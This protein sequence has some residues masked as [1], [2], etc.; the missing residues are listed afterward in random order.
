[1]TIPSPYLLYLGNSKDRLY[2]KTASGIA[3]WRPELV[4]GQY[5]ASDQERSLD[6]AELSFDEAV[7]AGA[8]TL[9]LGFANEGGYMPDDVVRDVLS[10]LR[11][12]LHVASGLHQHLRDNAQ[13]NELASELGRSLFDVRIPPDGL[14]VGT[15][16]RR[17]GR[18][19]LA[20]G[21]DCSVGKM[22]TSL[23]IEKELKRRNH[24]ARFRAT[25]QTGIL[26]AGGGVPLDAVPG[27]FLS[28]AI[29][30][31]SPARHDNGWDIIEGQ[32]SLFHPSFAAV[33]LGLL[34]G[35]Q[36]DALVLCHEAGRPHIRH[37]PGYRLPGLRECLDRNLQ[38]ARLTNSEAVAVGISLNTSSLSP[39]E[40]LDARTEAEDL[41]G[42]PCEDPLAT[43]VGRIVD[44]LIEEFA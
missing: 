17:A 28:G 12:G 29:E 24:L 16:A 19:L 38:E 30:Q 13:I 1:M 10:A 21:T 2:L 43:G 14:P 7:E 6:L 40:A 34:H 33:S 18:R 41:L 3:H 23:A 22:Y 8:K 15:G 39:A 5:R 4:L 26:I 37:L 11:A 42:L 27:D 20:V 25:G 32:G 9:V 44:R 35:A 31:L 36:P